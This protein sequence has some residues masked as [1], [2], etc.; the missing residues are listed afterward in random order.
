M[1][2]KLDKIQMFDKC[3]QEEADSTTTEQFCQ[4]SYLGQPKTFVFWNDHE[5]KKACSQIK[6]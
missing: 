2:A 5:V 4:N 6:I 3:N 1:K